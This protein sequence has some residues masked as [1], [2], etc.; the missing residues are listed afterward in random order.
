M[1]LPRYSFIFTLAVIFVAVLILYG[2]YINLFFSQDDFFHLKVSQTDGTVKEFLELGSFRPFLKRGGIYFYRPV[3]REYLFNIYY[4]LFGLNAFPFRI[5]QFLIHF[6]NIFLVYKLLNLLNKKPIAS[7]AGT[8]FFGIAAANIGVISYLAGGIQVAGSLT[9]Y[10]IAVFSF[11][12]YISKKHFKYKLYS[13]IAYVLALA[14]HELAITF[15]II[16]V[17]LLALNRGLKKKVLNRG[18]KE[19]WI[20]ALIAF[21]YIFLEFAIIGFPT[22][23]KQYAI[24]LSPVKLINS[25]FWYFLW[26]LGTPE[27]LLDFVGPGIKLNPNLM[28][29]WGEYYRVIFPSLI[30]LIGFLVVSSIKLTKLR[31]FWFFVIWFIVGIS[32]VIFQPAHRLYY[33]LGISLVGVSGVIGL[34][35]NNLFNQ[36][37]LLGVAFLATV[38]VLTI[39]SV[40][41]S[42][43]T[44]WAISRV[45]IAK[46]LIEDVVE[47]Y[48]ILPKGAVVYFTNDPN[49]PYLNEQWGRSSKQASIILSGSDAL[50]LVYKDPSLKVYY[51]EVE[52]PLETDIVFTLNAVIFR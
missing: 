32:P 39:V 21:V 49:H 36:K 17:G 8:F 31:T 13:L 28:K 5:T 22:G 46:R 4:N 18:V 12:K 29:Y 24:N 19:L 43:M 44:Y 35:F 6:I 10:L 45:N 47:K 20:F 1:T 33:Y 38:L 30:I 7:F 52:K 3:F 11:N 40:Q 41:L 27:M 37:K 48:P 9:F 16:A 42:D 14:S 15:P 26:S 23:E 25:Y 50:Q 2:K 51:E 34:I